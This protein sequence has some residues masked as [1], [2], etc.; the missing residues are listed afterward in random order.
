MGK[1]LF[2]N[3]PI[4]NGLKQQD[5]VTSLFFNFTPEY[6]IRRFQEI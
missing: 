3:F 5:A 6:A 1:D 2:E 4:E